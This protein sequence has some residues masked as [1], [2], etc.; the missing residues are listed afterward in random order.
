MSATGYRGI[1]EAVQALGIPFGTPTVLQTIGGSHVRS[2]EHY[3]LRAVDFGTA[4]SNP[5]AIYRAL[6]PLAIGADAPVDELFWD[7]SGQGWKNGADIGPI[8]GHSDHVHVGVRAGVALAEYVGGRVGVVGAQAPAG[9][10]S[11]A[12]Q[13]AGLADWLNPFG[14]PGDLAHA[15]AGVVEDQVGKVAGSLWGTFQGAAIRVGLVGAGLGLVGLGLYR[16]VNA[17]RGST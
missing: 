17:S 2:S 7:P 12:V 9:R 16:A 14:I 1:I 8:G 6:R 3:Q 10:D 11:A 13:A 4:S 15:A 5:D